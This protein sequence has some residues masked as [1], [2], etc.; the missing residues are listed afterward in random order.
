MKSLLAPIMVQCCTHLVSQ[1]VGGRQEYSHL[2][3]S[4]EGGQVDADDLSCNQGL[5]ST[6]T[7]AW[8]LLKT[9]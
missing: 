4:F 7:S 3:S 2:P 5:A 1:G 6:C 9:A 8:R